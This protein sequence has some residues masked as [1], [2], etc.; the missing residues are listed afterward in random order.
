MSTITTDQART[1]DGRFSVKSRTEPALSLGDPDRPIT[2]LAVREWV[3]TR[4]TTRGSLSG[5]SLSLS[6]LSG[7]DLPGVDL[8]AADLWGA[9]FDH[10]DMPGANLALCDLRSASFRGTHMPGVN[11]RGADLSGARFDDDT[12][13][14]GAQYDAA[15]MWP[16]G[17]T[18]PPAPAITA[19]EP[20]I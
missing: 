13:L 11:L 16:A 20:D 17:V 2:S 4:V 15:T 18:P 10:A 3:K 14:T 5:S 9:N 8:A 12:N 7:M 1:G 19:D 6:D